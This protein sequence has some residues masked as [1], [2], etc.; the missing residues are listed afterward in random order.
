MKP[1]RDVPKGE[2]GHALVPGSVSFVPPA[3]GLL[4]ASVVVRTLLGE[5]ET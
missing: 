3:A 5:T 4:A 2:S 1:L